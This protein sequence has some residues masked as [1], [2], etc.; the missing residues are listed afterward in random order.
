MASLRELFSSPAGSPGRSHE[1]LEPMPFGDSRKFMISPFGGEETLIS[2]Q[3]RGFEVLFPGRS[4]VPDS[5]SGEP[6]SIDCLPL[7]KQSSCSVIASYF[8]NQYQDFTL[9]PHEFWAI[10]GFQSHNPDQDILHLKEGRLSI[11]YVWSASETW[12]V[13][14]RYDVEGVVLLALSPKVQNV[15]IPG[16]RVIV[17]G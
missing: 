5:F 10:L 9:L 4:V 13:L 6:F 3:N 7:V 14:V 12:A 1:F 17:K 11:L 16:T 8:E 15:W 2:Y